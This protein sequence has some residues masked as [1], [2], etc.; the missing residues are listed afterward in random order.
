MFRAVRARPAGWTRR[1]AGTII[2]TRHQG[3]DWTLAATTTTPRVLPIWV[4][5][6]IGILA[7]STAA[8]LIRVA[9]APSLT[10][11]LYRCVIA[12][13]VLAPLALWRARAELARVTRGQLGWCALA[14]AALAAHFATW[15]TSLSM[16]TVA[17]S[18]ALVATTPVFVAVAG[19]WLLGERVGAGGWAGIALAVVGAGAL[20]GADLRVSGK[21]LAG[22]LLAVAG[23]V[24]AATYVLIG[25]RMRRELSLLPYAVA[26]Y[27]AAACLLL[28]AALLHGDQLGGF[29]AGQWAALVALGLGPQ[30]LGHTVFNFLLGHL[31]ADAVAVAVLG[32][33]VGASLIALVLLGEVPP[34]AALPGAALVLTGIWLT[35]KDAAKDAAV[36]AREAVA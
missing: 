15:V 36:G 27:A 6:T 21:A 5:L 3:S 30:V 25:R 10:V 17:S 29:A 16:T 34:L 2:A 31:R 7:V 35:L 24:F 14:G 23:A 13:A 4:W 9:E 22:D 8:P 33:P 26:V 28:P 1:G 19:T 12:L 20:A 18:T 32:E 11:A